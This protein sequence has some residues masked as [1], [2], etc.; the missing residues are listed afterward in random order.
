MYKRSSSQMLSTSVRCCSCEGPT[1]QHDQGRRALLNTG[2]S[3]AWMKCFRQQGEVIRYSPLPAHVRYSP[4]SRSC[5]SLGR[6]SMSTDS[7]DGSRSSRSSPANGDE[8]D[9]LDE[10]V[11]ANGSCSASPLPS[12]HDSEDVAD[13]DRSR[14]LELDTKMND[15]VSRRSSSPER[16]TSGAHAFDEDQGFEDEDHGEE[17]GEGEE[18]DEE[19][20][21]EEVR[22]AAV[23]PSD[24]PYIE[25]AAV[26]DAIGDAALAAELASGRPKR[27]RRRPQRWE[28]VQ[29]ADSRRT[30]RRV[31]SAAAASQAVASASAP[32]SGGVL[33]L[34][35]P[36][37]SRR[38]SRGSFGSGGMDLEDASTVSIRSVETVS[39]AP[40]AVDP[41]ESMRGALERAREAPGGK[42]AVVEAFN[43]WQLKTISAESS[44]QKLLHGYLRRKLRKRATRTNERERIEEDALRNACSAPSAPA[45]DDPDG[46]R[47]DAQPFVDAVGEPS[48]KKVKT[49]DA[50]VVPDKV[51]L[52]LEAYI[53]RR[54]RRAD[55]CLSVNEFMAKLPKPPPSNARARRIWQPQSAWSPKREERRGDGEDSESSDDEAHTEYKARRQEATEHVE[56][57][58]RP[59]PK[60]ESS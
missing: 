40:E 25:A 26:P 34:L 9:D 23:Q 1:G 8:A 10:A 14:S 58:R 55:R 60:V 56:E 59:Q 57:R 31:S 50:H 21:E 35:H 24:E 12:R 18:G 20:E 47:I 38:G 16:L 41:L 30:S 53:P 49:L 11:V 32:P 27:Q 22:Q 48:E 4:P 19:E 43:A 7:Q 15:G 44:H 33:A 13:D 17:G 3:I 39:P 5:R 36:T 54:V 6:V 28:G 51:R 2:V 29:P 45:D 37:P 42:R 52:P 46:L